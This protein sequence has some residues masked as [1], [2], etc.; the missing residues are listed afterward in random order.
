[1]NHWRILVVDDEEMVA[2]ALREG[3]ARLPNCDVS[4][5]TSA[6][7]A[8]YLFEKEP[9]DVVITDYRMPDSD[10]M[11]MVARMQQQ[12]PRTMAVVITAYAD[13]RLQEQVAW[14]SILRILDKPVTVDEIRKVTMEALSKV[15]TPSGR[16]Q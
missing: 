10:G 6:Q 14:A 11:T 15:K 1:M 9:F 8:L 2:I 5:A 13:H 7:E 16:C 12:R 4:M 3:L